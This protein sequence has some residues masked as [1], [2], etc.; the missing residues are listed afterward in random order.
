MRRL[1]HRVAKRLGSFPP[2]PCVVRVR[3]V[4]RTQPAWLLHL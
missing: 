1:R 2:V 3:A 4:V